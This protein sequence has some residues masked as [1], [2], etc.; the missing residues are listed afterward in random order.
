MDTPDGRCSEIRLCPRGRHRFIRKYFCGWVNH[1]GLDG[2]TL[3]GSTDLFVTKYDSSGAKLWTR[4]LGILNKTVQAYGV[5]T[6]TSGNVYITGWTAG[7][8]DGNTQAGIHDFFFTKYDTAGTK[9]FTK[10]LGVAAKNT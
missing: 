10:Q 8:L 2:N 4:Q 6:D 7:G 1:G 9:L 3:T 5:A